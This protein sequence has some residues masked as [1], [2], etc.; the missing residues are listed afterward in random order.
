MSQ[1]TAGPCF[2]IAPLALFV[3][4]PP[5]EANDCSFSTGVVVAL[6]RRVPVDVT[7]LLLRSPISCV[8][9]LSSFCLHTF[10]ISVDSFY[11]TLS[12]CID[13]SLFRLFSSLLLW[14]TDDGRV[15]E[16]CITPGPLCGSSAA[17]RASPPLRSAGPVGELAAPKVWPDDFVEVWS[18]A[19]N[20]ER[21]GNGRATLSLCFAAATWP[22]GSGR[23]RLPALSLGFARSATRTTVQS[24]T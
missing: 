23:G 12:A 3:S 5:A 8:L 20:G 16:R 6:G 24:R 17:H 15:R 13:V 9:S 2:C 1:W 10:I 4:S 11:F 14:R 19:R 22:R 21:A 18:R 7:R